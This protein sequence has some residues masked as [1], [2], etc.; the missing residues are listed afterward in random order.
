M[1]YQIMYCKNI[2]SETISVTI[3]EAGSIGEAVNAICTKLGITEANVL[4][5]LLINE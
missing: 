1:S 2:D 4:A 3:I 5:V